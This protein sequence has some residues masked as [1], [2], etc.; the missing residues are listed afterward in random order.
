M[1]ME[2]KDSKGKI[3]CNN[4]Y[5][6]LERVLVCPP[7]FMKIEEAINETQKHFLDE[8]IDQEKAMEQHREFIQALHEHGS[9]VIQLPPIN[10]FPEQ[11]FTRDIGFTI[12]DTVFIST[13]GTKMRTGE[14]VILQ[15][16][17]E[18]M[19]IKHEKIESFAIEGGDVVVDGSKVWVGV[20]SRTTEKAI[21]ELQS[22]LPDYQV[23]AVPF[24]SQFLHLDCLFNIVS[25]TEALIYSKAF[26]KEMVE[27]FAAH[28]TLI[29]VNDGEQFTMGPNVLSLGDRTLLSLPVNKEVNKELALSGYKVIELDISEIIKSGGSFRCC[30]LPIK[31]A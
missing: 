13:M 7:A 27:R 3:S 9:D 16:W 15:D 26:S 28:Y 11:V 2:S 17:L 12:G 14:E 21:E 20:S 6:R 4:E 29:E 22:K 19:G 5:D 31:R 30:S 18:E 25:P 8:N 24:D 10:K 1:L 23:M